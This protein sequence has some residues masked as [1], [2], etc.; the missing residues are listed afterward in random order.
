MMR[1]SEQFLELLSVSN[2]QA[3]T[4]YLIFFKR[5][6]GKDIFKKHFRMDRKYWFNFYRSSVIQSILVEAATNDGHWKHEQIL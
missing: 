2:K 3:E 4:L 5:R 1:L 6:Q